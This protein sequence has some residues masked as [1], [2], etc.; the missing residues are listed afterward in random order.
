MAPGISVGSSLRLPVGWVTAVVGFA[1]VGSVALAPAASSAT[2]TNAWQA[3]L[4]SAGVNGTAKVQA[5]STGAGSL[6]LRLA[7]LRPTRY[8]PVVLYK[9]T[10]RSVGPVLLR[11]TSIKTTTAGTA[12]RT[13]SLTTT[14]VKTIKAATKGTNRIAIRVGSGAT[15]GVKCGLFAALT[16]A[17]PSPKPTPSA[18]PSSSPSPSPSSTT[19]GGALILGPGYMLTMPDGWVYRPDLMPSATRMVFTDPR[20]RLLLADTIVTGLTLEELVASISGSTPAMLQEL[21]ENVT[22]GDVPGRLF[23]YHFNSSTGGARYEIDS[24]AVS[25]GRA[26]ELSFSNVAGTEEAD[27]AFFRTILAT[28]RFL[29]AGF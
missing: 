13:S 5:F 17:S 1:L 2:V 10:C 22:I 16:L 26:Y 6:T 28:F 27:L 23:A 24:F 14:Q 11:L 25:N 7:R 8:L 9:G 21:V 12:I 20:G 29:A 15:G 4:G 18:S 3:K 19:L